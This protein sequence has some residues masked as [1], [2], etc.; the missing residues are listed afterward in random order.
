[1]ELQTRVLMVSA[2]V[3]PQ[4]HVVYLEKHVFREHVNAEQ[5]PRVL[6]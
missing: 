5:L 3:A 1:M 6:E 2:S 4:M